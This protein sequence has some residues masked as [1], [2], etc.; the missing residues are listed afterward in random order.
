MNAQTNRTQEEEI[1][2]K[3]AELFGGETIEDM[4]KYIFFQNDPSKLDEKERLQYYELM[5]KMIKEQLPT[6]F[7]WSKE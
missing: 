1:N 5:F 7:G 2:A 3:F 6:L 4:F